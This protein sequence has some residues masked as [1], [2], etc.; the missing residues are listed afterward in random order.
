MVNL[1]RRVWNFFCDTDLA[2]I[3]QLAV[4]LNL[5]VGYFYFSAYFPVF[6]PLTYM[7]L[8][9]WLRTVA[10]GNLAETWWFFTFLLFMVALGLNMFVC[11][12]DKVA[13]IISNFSAYGSGLRFM[14]RLSPHL[15]HYAVL[16][17]L[18]G[19]LTLVTVGTNS[20]NNILRLDSK[21]SLPGSPYHLQLKKLEVRYYNKDA[22]IG[23]QGRAIDATADIAVDDG[24]GQTEIIQLGFNR[25]CWY[26]GYALHMD[27]FLPNSTESKRQEPYVNLIVRTGP[28]LKI[29][30][31]GVLLFLIGVV[32]YLWQFFPMLSVREQKA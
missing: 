24:Q 1:A 20:R 5:L 21:V 14:M 18:L 23:Y 3:L 2:V 8:P 30:L 26:K 7:M 17:I 10:L 15:I 27:E 16:L 13:K 12:T 4:C 11:T 31:A 9:D 22:M 29:F 28:G 19:H 32:F 6:R 25:P